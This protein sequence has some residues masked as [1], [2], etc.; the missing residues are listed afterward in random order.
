MNCKALS[1]RHIKIY[2]KSCLCFLLLLSLLISCA[3]AGKPALRKKS[4]I[5]LNKEQFG[6][7]FTGII[8]LDPEKGDTLL[9]VNSNSYFT[10]ASNTKLF[11]FYSALQLLPERIP[12]AH[13]HYQGD[14]LVVRGTGDPTQFHP[15]FQDSTLYRFLK[16]HPGPIAVYHD[17]FFEE[18][19]GPGWAWEDY[20][21]AYAPERNA[22][23][24][25]GN[26]VELS[27]SDSL[28]VTPSYFED[29]VI[30]AAYPYSRKL[31]QNL[32][33]FD[34]D[35]RD[36]IRVPYLTDTTLTRK[37]LEA[38]LQR[39]ITK[40]PLFSKEESKQLL[41]VA[42]DSVLKRMMQ[43]SDNFLAEQ[44]LLLVSGQ[45]SDSLN[46]EKAR[47][48]FMSMSLSDLVD[49]PRWVDGSGLSRYNLFTPASMVH[50]LFK[51][52]KQIPR[53]RL[54]EL[55]PAGGSSGTLE[56]WF[57]G[58][59]KPYIFAKS[60]TLGNNYNLSGYLI[61]RKGKTLIFSFMNNHFRQPTREIKIQMQEY[62]EWV[63]DT[64]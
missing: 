21:G 58:D 9:T 17:H 29:R 26:V 48:F 53:K 35:K 36:T 4:R 56:D 13:Y 40:A 55:L 51:L 8:I 7:H 22:L 6:N 16:Q 47:K 3:S 27:L 57:P 54:F 59:P 14:T 45:I 41:G 25:Y 1:F 49:P 34:R 24:L 44:L 60:G 52:Y 46:S 18:H 2:A 64:Y 15:Y 32:F 11:T 63:R 33:F 19:F 38:S 42:T 50:V 23:P 37:L 43:E 12:V 30:L 31:K 61:T 20:D 28:N 62:L 5:T 10:P 39:P